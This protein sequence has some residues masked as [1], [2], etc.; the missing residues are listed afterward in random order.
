MVACDLKMRQIFINTNSK[1][2]VWH[3]EIRRQ[4]LR[5]RERAG[6]RNFSA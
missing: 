4:I 3:S 5:L 6:K 2:L 1:A